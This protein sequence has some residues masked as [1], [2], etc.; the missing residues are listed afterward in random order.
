MTPPVT[1]N[2]NHAED[3]ED[4]NDGNK[5]EWDEDDH[6]RFED[7]RS[8]WLSVV[9]ISRRS[10]TFVVLGPDSQ[11]ISDQGCR[12]ACVRIGA[13]GALGSSG[14]NPS[15][16]LVARVIRLE[17]THVSGTHNSSRQTPIHSELSY[18]TRLP[19]HHRTVVV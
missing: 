13:Q 4:K 16:V 1:C 3:E 2:E 14:H 10:L 11:A 8:C 6:R 17:G 15:T 5:K 12:V 7:S 19:F 18:I 9:P